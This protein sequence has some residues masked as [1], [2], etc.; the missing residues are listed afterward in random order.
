MPRKPVAKKPTAP[1]APRV[2]R[3]PKEKIPKERVP[4]FDDRDIRKIERMAGYG[5]TVKMIAAIMGVTD[6][7]LRERAGGDDVLRCALERGKARVAARVSRSL[8]NRALDPDAKDQVAAIRWFEMTR[9]GLTEKSHVEQS[10]SLE[11]TIKDM[12]PEERRRRIRKYE[13]KLKKL[14]TSPHTERPARE[15]KDDTADGE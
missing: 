5:L 11:V 9:R 4:P 2:P 14:H 8:V 13:A 10:G 12:P 6:S 7:C 3:P 15:L 1:K